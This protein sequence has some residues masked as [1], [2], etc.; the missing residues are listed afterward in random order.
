MQ[1]G[2]NKEYSKEK[3]VRNEDI[4]NSPN[5]RMSAVQDSDEDRD[6]NEATGSE[7]NGENMAIQ[8]C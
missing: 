3:F 1:L 2:V 8:M 4:Y 6:I 7:R 5:Y